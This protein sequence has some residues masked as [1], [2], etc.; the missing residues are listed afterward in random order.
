MDTLR[1]TCQL[2]DF[3]TNRTLE[4][5]IQKLPLEVVNF[6]SYQES[7]RTFM[8]CKFCD[9]KKQ[10]KLEGDRIV[11]HATNALNCMYDGIK[12]KT[13]M[14]FDQN[15]RTQLTQNVKTTSRYR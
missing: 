10:L 6:H 9:T 15:N 5:L 4:L 7:M 1:Y 13:K 3:L 14:K 2:K 12:L 11:S 8:V